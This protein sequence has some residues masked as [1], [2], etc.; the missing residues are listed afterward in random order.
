MSSLLFLE[1]ETV[2]RVGDGKV[3]Q[4]EN[5]IGKSPEHGY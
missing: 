2:S 1:V 3:F 4:A 5:D